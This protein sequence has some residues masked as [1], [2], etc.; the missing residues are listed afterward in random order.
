[1]KKRI[2]SFLIS[3]L[4]LT[5]CGN[6]TRTESEVESVSESN[7]TSS[8]S[9]QS[10]TTDQ[11]ASSSDNEVNQSVMLSDIVDDSFETK[12]INLVH[13]GKN[14]VEFDDGSITFNLKAEKGTEYPYDCSAVILNNTDNLLYCDFS[15]LQGGGETVLPILTTCSTIEP[16]SELE[17]SLMFASLAENQP[18][19]INFADIKIADTTNKILYEVENFSYEYEWE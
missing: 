11:T 7:P 17:K 8:S 1:M 5:S 4:I 6:T 10:E 15:G 3:M 14:T 13:T 12:K 18:L 19:K 9:S 2:S 16:H